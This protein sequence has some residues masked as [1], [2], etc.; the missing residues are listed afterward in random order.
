MER[1]LVSGTPC[2]VVVDVLGRMPFARAH[3]VGD[4]RLE[5]D[6]DPHRRA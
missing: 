3:V 5:L 1:P 6:L 2:A 4:G